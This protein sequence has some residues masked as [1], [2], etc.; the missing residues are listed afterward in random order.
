MIT[1]ERLAEIEANPREA[2]IFKAEMRELVKAYQERVPGLSVKKTLDGTWLHVKAPS[3]KKAMI[4]LE[5]LGITRGGLVGETLLEWV[6]T[7]Q[8]EPPEMNDNL[9]WISFELSDDS[10]LFYHHY[11]ITWAPSAEAA[12][13][14]LE[15]RHGQLALEIFSVKPFV[16]DQLYDRFAFEDGPFVLK[17]LDYSEPDPDE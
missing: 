13:K 9:W 3:G 2:S 17:Q 6:D 1:N 16:V 10:A 15:A 12:C 5:A 11:A 8:P 4:S 7:F 14:Q